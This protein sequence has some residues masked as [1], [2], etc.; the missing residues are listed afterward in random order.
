MT[1]PTLAIAGLF[2]RVSTLVIVGRARETSV[3]AAV[4]CSEPNAGPTPCTY[5]GITLR[6]GPAIHVFRLEPEQRRFQR[7]CQHLLTPYKEKP[8]RLYWRS[9]PL[10]NTGTQGLTAIA[11]AKKKDLP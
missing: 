6:L 4:Q 1:N 9:H 10:N 3:R 11:L 2:V 7:T 8:E 5:G